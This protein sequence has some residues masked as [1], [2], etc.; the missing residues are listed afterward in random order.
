MYHHHTQ[1]E[2]QAA[3]DLYVTGGHSPITVKRT[4][5]YPDASTLSRW[6]RDY[7]QRGYV[8]G[9]EKWS[10]KFTEEQERIAVEHYLSTGKNGSKAARE[11]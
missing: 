5:G 6:Y 9:P 10:G 8:R 3:I 7:L 2:K 11:L 1:E 4:L